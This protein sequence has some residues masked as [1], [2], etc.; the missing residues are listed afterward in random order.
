MIGK[1]HVGH[2]S[3]DMT[4]LQRGMDFFQ[5]FM[6]SGAIEFMEKTNGNYYDMFTSV[7]GNNKAQPLGHVNS[8][9]M[10][11]TVRSS[12][13]YT[14]GAVRFI[15]NHVATASGKQP[16]FMY[17]AHQ[18]PHT[19]LQSPAV[20]TSTAP[21]SSLADDTRKTYCGMMRSM[22]T[23]VESL[24]V[25]LE[26]KQLLG[27]TLVIFTGD[28]GG[29]P[30]NGGYNYPFR[31]SKGTLFDGGIKQLTWMWG[32]MLPSSL[33]GR[34]NDAIFHHADL[35]PTFLSLATSGHWRWHRSDYTLDGVD[36]WPTIL[37]SQDSP[38]GS[39]GVAGTKDTLLNCIDDSGGLRLGDYVL[40]LNTKDDGWY[41]H[42][43]S[44]G[45]FRQLAKNNRTKTPKAWSS[46]ADKANYLFNVVNDPYQETNLYDT[47]PSLVASMTPILN[48]YIAVQGCYKCDT[49]KED[50]ATTAAA[51]VGYWVPWLD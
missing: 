51:A 47:M 16:F 28:N 3:W 19:P 12:D 7:A 23:N 37:G 35:L 9:M 30:K 45:R 17:W 46:K 25:E 40:L 18:D 10:A 50:A 8:S 31:G 24:M 42:P 29:A 21:C 49:D 11:D 36:Q 13:I 1:W 20:Y 26:R 39:P 43:D 33:T 38:R 2:A 4:P 44:D 5:G 22:D 48:A 32:A 41:P 27:N 15:D 14:E 34:W 6:C